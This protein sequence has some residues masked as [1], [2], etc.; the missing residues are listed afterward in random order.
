M[1]TGGQLFFLALDEDFEGL[2]HRGVEE[3]MDG[4]AFAAELSSGALDDFGNLSLPGLEE[5]MGL[6][7]EENRLQPELLPSFDQ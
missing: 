7:S 5:E 3:L 2:A 1:S 6:V 4:V